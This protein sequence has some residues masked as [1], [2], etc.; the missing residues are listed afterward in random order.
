MKNEIVKVIESEEL[1]GWMA[2]MEEGSM[3]AK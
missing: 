2:L 1:Y 3:Q